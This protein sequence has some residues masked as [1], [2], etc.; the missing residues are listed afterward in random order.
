MIH[1]S[2]VEKDADKSLS[3]VN[4]CKEIIKDYFIQIKVFESFDALI[5]DEEFLHKTEL[6]IANVLDENHVNAVKSLKALHASMSTIFYSNQ[7]QLA[8]LLYEVNPTYFIY[9]KQLFSILERAL[10]RC[11]EAIQYQSHKK[12]AIK[13][14]SKINIIPIEEIV[15]IERLNRRLRICTI[16]D[17]YSCYTSFDDMID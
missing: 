14:N 13:Y 6:L 3:I 11:L 12:L 16:H 15:L 10:L 8:T 17:E 9:D 1:I 2:I 5:L 4:H 7:L